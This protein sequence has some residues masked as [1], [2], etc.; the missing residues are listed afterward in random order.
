MDYYLEGRLAAEEDGWEMCGVPSKFCLP[1]LGQY[2][3]MDQ[4]LFVSGS[5]SW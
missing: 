5:E 2:D 3:L 4:A 1:L